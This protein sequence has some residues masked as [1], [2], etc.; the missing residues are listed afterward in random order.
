MIEDESRDLYN[1]EECGAEVEPDAAIVE[2]Y[3]GHRGTVIIAF[4]PDCS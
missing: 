4:C 1:C 3:P 2:R